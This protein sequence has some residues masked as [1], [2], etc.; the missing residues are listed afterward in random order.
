M[1]FPYGSVF[2]GFTLTQRDLLEQGMSMDLVRGKVAST[3]PVKA[4]NSVIVLANILKERF[5]ELEKTFMEQFTDHIILGQSRFADLAAGQ[6]ERQHRPYG[7]LDFID[8][9][10]GMG[11]VAGLKTNTVAEGGSGTSVNRFWQNQAATGVQKNQLPTTI[12]RLEHESMRFGSGRK[13][14][15]CGTDIYQ[16]MLDMY[17]AEEI[18]Q[19][20]NDGSQGDYSHTRQPLVQRRQNVQ[21]GTP[22]NVEL[23]TKVPHINGQPVMYSHE[24]DRLESLVPGMSKRLYAIDP[25]FMRLDEHS[26][27]AM[28]SY[29]PIP[30]HDRMVM[31]YGKM[32][33]YL[34]RCEKR[35]CHW[36]LEMA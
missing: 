7:I 26:A 10:P 29:N 36:M 33:S 21:P 16:A 6:E 18:F 15:F 31:Y 22:V 35:N 19:V 28:S 14:L 12:R 11:S 5:D 1:S 23:I 4:A 30:E 34:M 20:Q 9:M 8:D 13:R 17:D 27:H 24:L 32:L 3:D 2:D 25:Q